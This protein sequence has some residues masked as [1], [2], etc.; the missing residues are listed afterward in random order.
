MGY[1]PA[2]NLGTLHLIVSA[3]RSG[4]ILTGGAATSFTD[5]DFGPYTPV[6][7]KAVHLRADVYTSG[8]ANGARDDGRYLFKAKG[9]SDSTLTKSAA[10]GFYWLNMAAGLQ[11]AIA[12]EIVV[13]CDADRKIQYKANS[14]NPLAE[15]NLNIMGYYL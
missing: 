4:Y 3:S 1:A 15:I 8:R 12:T 10:A 14:G 13:E 7:T 2:I 5:V 11:F 6:G 9:A